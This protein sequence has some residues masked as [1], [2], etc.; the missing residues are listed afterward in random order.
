MIDSNEFYQID[1]LLEKAEVTDTD[2]ICKALVY[3][4]ARHNKGV[5]NIS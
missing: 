1:T 4:W 2:N 5:K 3:A